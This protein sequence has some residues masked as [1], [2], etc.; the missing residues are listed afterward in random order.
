MYANGLKR[1]FVFFC[2]LAAICCLSPL[3]VFLTVFGAVLR[4][5]TDF[6]DNLL[7]ADRI[8]CCEYNRGHEM[9]KKLF[10]EADCCSK[11]TEWVVEIP[12]Y[13]EAA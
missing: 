7:A 1:V 12:N 3:L 10:Q 6:G 4:S 8:N 5:A 13:R 11:N 2:A 9:A